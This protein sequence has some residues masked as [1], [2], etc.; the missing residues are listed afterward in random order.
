MTQATRAQVQTSP[1][2]PYASAPRTKNSGN[3]AKSAFES[4]GA[5][6]LW[7]REC[8]AASPPSWTAF[9]HLL[10]A[11][12]VTPGASATSACVQPS[13]LSSSARNRRISFQSGVRMRPLFMRTLY[14]TRG[15]P[16]NCNGL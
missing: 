7:G 16:I 2:N 5:A 12:L 14:V 11:I 8:K 3:K 6:P 15:K 13:R 4:W 9:I 10:T 1:R